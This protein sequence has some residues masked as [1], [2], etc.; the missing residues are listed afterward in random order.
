MSSK[1][2]NNIVFY[3]AGDIAPF[4]EDTNTIFSHVKPV[5][6]KGDLAF[7]QL[8]SLISNRG[9][10]LPHRNP[11]AIVDGKPF[12]HQDV[13]LGKAIKNAGFDVVSFAGN[14]CL[15]LG[16]DAFFDTIEAVKKRA[17]I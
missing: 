6:E 17:C 14:P 1:L 10:R 13:L 2:D 15:D 4:R 11:V 8:E 9:I 16:D 3:A 12:M 7:C 5:I